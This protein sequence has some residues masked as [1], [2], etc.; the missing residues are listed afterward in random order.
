MPTPTP[1]PTPTPAPEQRSAG[2][3]MEWQ[4]WCTLK[5]TMHTNTSSPKCRGMDLVSQG[6][7]KVT[8]KLLLLVSDHGSGTTT[9][10]DTM[11]THEC[12]FSLHEPFGGGSMVRNGTNLVGAFAGVLA[13]RKNGRLDSKIYGTT[14]QTQ[15]H[16]KKE[17]WKVKTPVPDDIYDCLTMEGLATYLMR[18]A[19]YVCSAMPEE[20][21][22][23]CGGTCV[24]AAKLFP[25]Y[26]GGEAGGGGVNSDRV[27]DAN[28]PFGQ[29]LTQPEPLRLWKSILTKVTQMP[30]VYTAVLARDEAKRA[31]SV[32]RRFAYQD[33]WFN[34]DVERKP[35]VYDQS[36]REI[37][38]CPVIDMATCRS[39]TGAKKCLATAL[40][41][42][43]LNASE[44]DTTDMTE[45]SIQASKGI[46]ASCDKG[47]WLQ[48]PDGWNKATSVP[49][50]TLLKEAKRVM[51]AFADEKARRQLL[52]EFCGMHIT[53]YKPSLVP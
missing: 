7:S 29:L 24:A 50:N 47:G 1:T 14:H 52:D 45:P 4:A 12:V 39:E 6:R 26:V 43:G 3:G 27:Y 18:V 41:L 22:A 5:D 42:V 33:T 13:T 31:L 35:T 48:V 38:R 11:G 8:T 28:D 37:T 25:T 2:T 53:T 23:K 34:C 51:H 17:G 30:D 32:W 49:S 44:M 20:T 40:D 36:A 46:Q 21:A 19:R 10:L 9:Y 16:K 15:F